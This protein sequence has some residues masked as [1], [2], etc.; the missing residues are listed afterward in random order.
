MFFVNCI[1]KFILCVQVVHVFLCTVSAERQQFRGSGGLPLDSSYTYNN[2]WTLGKS[3]TD[4]GINDLTHKIRQELDKSIARHLE[5]GERNVT[6]VYIARQV[7][8]G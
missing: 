6:N 7:D 2:A 8:M 5:K 1:L 4:H 3:T